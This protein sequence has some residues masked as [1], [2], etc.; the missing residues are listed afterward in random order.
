[1]NLREN[2]DQVFNFVKL[3]VKGVTGKSEKSVDVLE[4]LNWAQNY[5]FDGLA[6]GKS[7]NIPGLMSYVK[8]SEGQKW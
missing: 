2:K 1:M 8:W 6:L 3:H 5:M 7:S 4:S